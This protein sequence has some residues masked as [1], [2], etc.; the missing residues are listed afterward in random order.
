MRTGMKYFIDLLSIDYQNI[1]AAFNFISGQN[2]SSPNSVYGENW[3]IGSS[4]GVLNQTGVFFQFRG[5]GHFNGSTYMN[6]SKPFTFDNNSAI[7]FSYEK[8]NARD[9]IIM[10]SISG[11]TFNNY[12]GFC[13][14][15]NNANKL[16]F[17]YWNPVEG[18]FTFTFRKNLADKNLIIL[19]KNNDDLTIGKF[20]NNLFDFELENFK[21]KNNAFRE[22][23]KLIIGGMPNSIP[24]A[25][26]DTNNFSG[27]IDNFYIFK[28]T[29][30]LYKNYYASGLVYSPTGAEGLTGQ[31]CFLTGYLS[32]SGFS[33]TGVT[34]YLNQPFLITGTG[35]TGTINQ[36]ITGSSYSGITGYSNISLGFFNDGC[37]NTQQ[38]FGQT[39][40]SGLITI[41]YTGAINLTGLIITTGYNQ[42]PLSGP[43]TGVEYVYITGQSCTPFFQITGNVLFN[44]D[45]NFLKSLSYSQIS[46]LS[47]IKSGNHILEIYNEPYQTNKLNYNTNL[48]YS[49]TNNNIYN[50]QFFDPSFDN[51]PSGIL[52]YADKKLILN[53]GFNTINTGYNNYIIPIVDYYSTG[54]I[55]YTNKNYNESNQLFYDYFT[56]SSKIIKITGIS[57][58]TA[59]AGENFDKSFI[60]INGIKLISGKGFLMPNII[61]IT[62]PSGNN[63]IFVKKIPNFFYKSG[64][65]STLDLNIKNLNDSCSQI[66]FTGA[67]QKLNQNYI[68]NSIYDLLSG[69]F[70]ESKN[71]FIIYD[72]TQDFFV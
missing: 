31:N 17:K 40:L 65:I 33:F 44:Q 52:L 5:T 61:N 41:T 56:G 22:S 19:N 4:S 39:P 57:A 32:G 9:E 58:G 63:F 20:N 70:F 28:N 47:E 10:S 2:S 37:G 35:I 25:N 16:Y 8:T 64:N 66:F 72:N 11:T 46:L 55:V 14:G 15:V 1:E 7:L 48:Q 67:K 68:E 13:L 34:G 18:P 54:N 29:S 23:N 26:F 60:F 30:F 69:N 24:W 62:V 36:N 21:F 6:L 59:L 53:S 45:V 50:N 27:Y 12:S 3:A 51:I 43:I 42:I 71:N 49:L 38:I